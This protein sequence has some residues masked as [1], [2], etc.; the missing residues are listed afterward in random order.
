MVG[1]YSLKWTLQINSVNGVRADMRSE[2]V[3]QLVSGA[4]PLFA[5]IYATLLGFRLLGKKPGVNPKLDQ[6]H[7]RYGI[8][9]KVIGPSLVLVGLFLGINIIVL[10]SNAP[11]I[12]Q[13]SNWKRYAT[14]DGVCSAEFPEQPIES[15]QSMLGL[16]SK[17]LVVSLSA[18]RVN[19]SLVYSTYPLDNG[20][21]DEA[22]LDALRDGPPANGA[23]QGLPVKFVHEERI[24]EDGVEGREFEYDAGD[25]LTILAKAFI[26]GKRAYQ[27]TAVVPRSNKRDGGT[28][29]FLDSIRFDKNRN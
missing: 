20:Q 16:E 14:S 11:G 3:G 7:R 27:M 26:F 17:R 19:Y 24:T 15:D 21:T 8:F 4:I 2:V 10:E 28:V 1:Q 18:A 6:W 5:G 25:D 29:W 12:P 9:L 23:R 13:V 22:R